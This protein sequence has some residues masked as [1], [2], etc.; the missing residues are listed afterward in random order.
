MKRPKLYDSRGEELN[1]GDLVRLKSG[2]AEMIINEIYHSPN[3]N[4]WRVACSW[5]DQLQM[6]QAGD[7][8]PT[9]LIKL[10]VS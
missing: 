4:E 9:S 2:G 10:G 7:Y 3:Y 1:N 6:P 8:P 5:Q